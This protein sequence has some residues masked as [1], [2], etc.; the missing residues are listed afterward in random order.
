MYP[1]TSEVGST[2]CG[3]AISPGSRKTSRLQK[4]ARSRGHK[5]P[6]ATREPDVYSSKTKIVL[7]LAAAMSFAASA[8]FAQMGR[9][10]PSEKKIVPDPVTGLPLA[11]LT[12]TDGGY[13]QSKIY[14]THR[15][16]TA[17]GKWLIFR[18]CARR[19][20][21]LRGE[22]G[23][24]DIVQVT[25]TGFSGMLCAGN[26]TMKLYVLAGGG[27]AATAGRKAREPDPAGEPATPPRKVE[28][29]RG[30]GHADSRDRPRQA[31]RRRGRRDRETCGQLPAR[32]RNDS[33]HP[34]GRWQH[35]SGC[36]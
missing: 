36:Q 28:A 24:G 29:A 12:S 16:W 13:R 4:G 8:A 3:S 15:Q 33:G 2:K 22:R 19:A 10:W 14:Q 30:R 21:R 1:K 6:T 32:L 20:R 11:F 31:L 5:T 34:R 35:G 26:K 17:D 23:D 7:F 9:R 25:E 18:G 27:G